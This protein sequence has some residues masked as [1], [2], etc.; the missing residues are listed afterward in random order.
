MP[1]EV[2]HLAPVQPLAGEGDVAH[3]DHGRSPSTTYMVPI[4]PLPL[5][6]YITLSCCD[7]EL[8]E[9]LEARAACL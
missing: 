5:I 6:S 3:K 9:G 2:R 7:T 1:T 8:Y 4:S